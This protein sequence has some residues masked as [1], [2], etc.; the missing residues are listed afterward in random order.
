[1]ENRFDL[2]EKLRSLDDV[3]WIKWQR[4]IG[5][6][7]GLAVGAC[8]FLIPESEGFLPINFL[9]G[10]VIAITGPRYLERRTERDFAEGRKI[11]LIT[12]CVVIVG[13]LAY[14]GVTTGFKDIFVKPEATPV[15][16]AA[17]AP[18]APPAA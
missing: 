14:I 7:M 6:I 12:L 9:A 5:L 3:Q 4:I 2:M 8:L 15:P 17:P 16:D 10:F 18:T 13:Y 1:M 11:M